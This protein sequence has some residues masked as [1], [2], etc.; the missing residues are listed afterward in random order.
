MSEEM[1]EEVNTS[2]LVSIVHCMLLCV[3]IK[4]QSVGRRPASDLTFGLVKSSR[5]TA[6][7]A[8]TALANSKAGSCRMMAVMARLSCLALTIWRGSARSQLVS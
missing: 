4:N 1:A 2:G 6:A 5:S 7:K 3:L 8:E